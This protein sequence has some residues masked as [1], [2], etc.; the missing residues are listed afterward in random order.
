[1]YFTL[2][3]LNHILTVITVT[4]FLYS[5]KNFFK[6]ILDSA[7]LPGNIENK[8]QALS[9]AIENKINQILAGNKEEVLGI[10]IPIYDIDSPEMKELM[11]VKTEALKISERHTERDYNRLKARQDSTILAINNRF[12]NTSFFIALVSFFLLILSAGF[13]DVDSMLMEIFLTLYN[14]ANAIILLIFYCWSRK[15]KNTWVILYFL[16]SIAVAYLVPRFFHNFII[17]TYGELHQSTWA[18]NLI[19]F[20]D[21]KNAYSF[22]LFISLI[23]LLSPWI[24][25]F[26]HFLIVYFFTSKRLRKLAK[27]CIKELGDL[28]TYLEVKARVIH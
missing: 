19:H 14:I 13:Q 6:D 20:L 23:I 9:S 12:S 4:A 3:S 25:G 11:E 8:V 10:E 5:R 18:N 1:M 27:P 21:N 22:V 24:I 26:L 28:K 17:G 15:V 16:G 2:E 7:L